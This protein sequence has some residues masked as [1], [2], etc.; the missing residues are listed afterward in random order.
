M[1]KACH[2]LLFI[3][4]L[5]GMISAANATQPFLIETPPGPWK[6]VFSDEFSTSKL[7]RSKWVQCYWWADEIC[8]NS[9][10]KEMQLY[11]RSNSFVENDLLYLRADFDA[12]YDREGRF[13]PYSSGMITS[14]ISYSEKPSP[15]RFSF[16]YGFV[17]V[18]AKIPSGKGLWPALWLLPD[19][20]T[21]RPE[22]DIME[23]LGDTPEKLRMH[24]HFHDAQGK[25]ES[26]GETLTL[27][28]L[29]RDWH[30]YGLLWQNDKIVW[31]LDGKEK[32]RFSESEHVP[33]EPLYLLANLAVGG[34]WPGAPDHETSFPADFLI[35]YVRIWQTP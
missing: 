9:G 3:V 4:P 22:I 25:E 24:F 35:D 1:A 11:R 26:A 8:T 17:E 29:S 34:E 19:K 31:Y 23:I 13:Y 33:K 7:D 28:D 15:A 18:R 20:L 5:L 27:T 32:W 10:N 21:S 30:I 14:S 16:Q 2:L 6:L 12:G